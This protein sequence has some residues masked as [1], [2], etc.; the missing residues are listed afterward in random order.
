MKDNYNHYNHYNKEMM[1]LFHHLYTV[2]IKYKIEFEKQHSDKKLT[3][4]NIILHLN[5]FI[6]T[7]LNYTN[8]TYFYF[9]HN[10]FIGYLY[11]FIIIIRYLKS[12]LYFP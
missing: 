10:I 2:C 1:H 11:S 3:A 5:N 7:T 6:T 12:H 8:K 9:I 4:D